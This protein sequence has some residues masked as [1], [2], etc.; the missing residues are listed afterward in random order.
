MRKLVLDRRST[1]T[2]VIA[3]L[4]VLLVLPTA[5]DASRPPEGVPDGGYGPTDRPVYFVVSL[6]DDFDVPY[7]D[8]VN[9]GLMSQAEELGSPV[10]LVP[11]GQYVAGNDIGDTRYEGAGLSSIDLTNLPIDPLTGLPM[12]PHELNGNQVTVLGSF[13]TFQDEI[14]MVTPDP[15]PI[16]AAVQEAFFRA[17]ALFDQIPSPYPTTVELACFIYENQ[18]GAGANINDILAAITKTPMRLTCTTCFAEGDLFPHDPKDGRL[19]SFDV[20]FDSD[21]GDFELNICL[22]IVVWIKGQN[23]T[24]PFN[25]DSNGVLPVVV[26]TTEHFNPT[27]ELDVESF[28][29]GTFVTDEAGI[30]V[31]VGVPPV[32]VTV[33][34]DGD[35]NMDVTFHF[36]TEAI[37][38]L[39]GVD[40]NTTE[41]RFA[42]STKLGMC[43]EGVDKIRVV[44]PTR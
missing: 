41:L 28:R 21:T 34:E 24:N 20:R 33:H 44:P 16:P 1:F 26:P 12:E 30:E 23:D 9:G 42:G 11:V 39:E 10:M 13:C 17:S 3:L 27:E 7:I 37:V 32:K 35:G 38:A 18:G 5:A 19:F 2:T 8:R 6:T 15:D 40:E 36:D 14:H 43:V 29:I 22:P 31:F 25:L 4:A